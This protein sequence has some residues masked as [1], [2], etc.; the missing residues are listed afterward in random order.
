M[1]RQVR[2]IVAAPLAATDDQRRDILG[3]LCP[4]LVLERSPYLLCPEA[5]T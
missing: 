2:A 4:N 5:L 1:D 3:A